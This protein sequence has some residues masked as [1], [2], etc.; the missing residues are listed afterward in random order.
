[1]SEQKITSISY[2]SIALHEHLKMYQ[3]VIARMAKNSSA[4]KQW[5]VLIISAIFALV[6]EK[7]KV[8]FAV[9]AIIPLILF[10][11]IDTYY[12][13][14]ERKFVD[15]NNTFLDNLEKKLITGKDLFRIKPER[16]AL[17]KS[18]WSAFWSPA[19]YPFYLGLLILLGLAKHI[20]TNGWVWFW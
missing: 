1:M 5:C 10:A 15:A 8:D 7:G 2:E 13:A 11:F 16:G 20:T 17:P 12:L 3:G 4:S 18:M 9:L 6:A 19:T 14:M